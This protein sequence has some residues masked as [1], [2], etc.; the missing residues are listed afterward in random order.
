MCRYVR[1]YLKWW[2]YV[3]SLEIIM[4]KGMCFYA[5]R[6]SN[7]WF[8]VPQQKKKVSAKEI[9]C[10]YFPHLFFSQTLQTASLISQYSRHTLSRNDKLGIRDVLVQFCTN[11]LILNLSFVSSFISVRN[12]R[13]PSDIHHHTWTTWQQFNVLELA[14]RSLIPLAD[15]TT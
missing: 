12:I 1:K 2:Q 5:S 9:N 13:K 6:E 7:F 15:C 14:P 3:I 11:G 8:I 4:L 10:F